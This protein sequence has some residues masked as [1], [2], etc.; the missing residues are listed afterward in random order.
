M[1]IAKRRCRDWLN[2][3]N[4]VAADTSALSGASSARTPPAF[5]L[6]LV[7]LVVE[8]DPCDCHRLQTCKVVS[9]RA[10]L[11]QVPSVTVN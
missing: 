6:A 8:R 1:V 10:H 11:E 4:V 3:E 7:M 2:Q 9:V 5:A